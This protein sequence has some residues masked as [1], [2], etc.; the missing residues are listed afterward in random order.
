EQMIDELKCAPLLKGIRGQ[1]AANIEA[2]ID[3]LLKL[4]GEDGLLARFNHNIA[5]M[6]LNPVIIDDRGLSIADARFMVSQTGTNSSQVPPGVNSEPILELLNHLFQPRTIAVVGASSKKIVIANTFIQRMKEF[7]YDGE[8]YPIHPKASLIEGLK[9]YPDLSSTP[10]PVDYAYIAIG[11]AQI[12]GILENANGNC[13]VAQV[14]SSGFGEVAE[15]KSLESDLVESARKGQVRILGPNC[16]GTY[17]PRGGL[18]FPK[19]APTELGSIGVVSQSGGLST[20]IVKRGQ[21]KGLRFS[22]LVTIGNS[23]DLTPADII[24]YFLED[25]HTTAIGLYVEDAKDGREIFNLMRASKM[26]KPL[27]ILKGGLSEQG[28]VAAASHTG[29]LAENNQS[30][31]ALCQQ[32]CAVLVSTVDEFIDTLLALQFVD[33]QKD[34]PTQNVTLFGNGGGA[35]V[36]GVDA[37]AD[38]NLSVSQF[39][40]TATDKLQALKLPAGTSVLNPIDTPVGTLLEKEGW[41][42]AEILDIVYRDTRTDAVVMHLNLAAF[43]GR[44]SV[45]PIDNL[46]AVMRKAKSEWSEPIHFILVLRS[47]GSEVIDNRKRE[48]REVAQGYRIPVFDEI[49]PVAQVLANIRHFEKQLSQL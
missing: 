31:F 7:D 42:A 18:T 5:E 37:F 38:K 41:I 49:A 16:L 29:A 25:E 17:S 11:A 47:D 10:K 20:D 2:L 34:Q 45:D 14:I 13:K 46:F 33:L 1:T 4:G 3:T 21:W 39:E 40:Q 26:I 43:V 44:G 24:R 8:I 28:A 6:D 48:L 15:S 22:G 27:V 36:L 23:A 30:W 32:C 35:S 19:D 9:T 12:P